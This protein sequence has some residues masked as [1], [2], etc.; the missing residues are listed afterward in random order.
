MEEFSEVKKLVH[1]IDKNLATA[2]QK[3]DDFSSQNNKEHEGIMTRQDKTNGRV[4]GLEKW[5]WG[6]TGGLVVVITLL[7][8]MFQTIRAVL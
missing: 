2:I 5:R 3:L 1:S 7:G 4:R 6:I 8:W